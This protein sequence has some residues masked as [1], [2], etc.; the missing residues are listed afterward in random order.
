MKDFIKIPQKREF[1]FKKEKGIKEKIEKLTVTKLELDDGI[2]I[3]GESFNVFQAKQVLKA[4]GRGFDVNDALNL[5]DDD[6]GLEVIDLTEFTKTKKKLKTLKGRIIG[7]GGKTKKQ[8]EKFT[9]V[10]LSVSGKTVSIIG[11]WEKIDIAKEALMKLIR[12]C[13]HQTLYRWLERQ[14]VKGEW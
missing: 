5:L 2:L 10:K 9:D 8:I 12:G 1:L 4:F 11:R 14:A 7:T 6:Y 3:E 13:M